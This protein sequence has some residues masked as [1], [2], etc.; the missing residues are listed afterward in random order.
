MKARIL[1]ALRTKDLNR[2][3]LADH[4]GL[5]KAWATKLFKPRDEGGLKTLSD[6]LVEK[7]ESFLGIE[8][9]VMVDKRK[10]VSGTALKLSELAEGDEALGS[11]PVTPICCK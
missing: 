10:A 8:L 2:V 3:D 5:G 1:H 9:L 11:N 6:D 4:V 7:V